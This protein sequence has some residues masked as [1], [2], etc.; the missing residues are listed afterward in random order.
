MEEA[1]RRVG[2]RGALITPDGAFSGCGGGAGITWELTEVEVYT[3]T[4][5]GCTVMTRG[6]AN[7]NLALEFFLSIFKGGRDSKEK[8][9][10][11]EDR[12][13]ENGEVQVA[14]PSS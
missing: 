2:T 1:Q 3:E 8:Y 14:N 12:S 10:T 13:T 6:G 5:G 9:S 11:R 4:G 7:N